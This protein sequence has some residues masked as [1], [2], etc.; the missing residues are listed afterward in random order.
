MEQSHRRVRRPAGYVTRLGDFAWSPMTWIFL[1]LFALAEV[2]NWQMG[3]EI[4]R[5]CE[6]LGQ[7]A[8]STSAAGL[9]KEEIEGICRNRTPQK[10]AY[11]FHR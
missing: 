6:L 7:G 10:G 3:N 5:V 8:L 2:G 4:A 11:A 1:G 9:A